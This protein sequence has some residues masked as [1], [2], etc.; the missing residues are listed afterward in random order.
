M[1]VERVLFGN[2][3]DGR[4]VYK[5]II[6]NSNECA[7]HILTLGATL[8]SFEIKDKNGTVKDVLLGLDTFDC[9]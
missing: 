7:A 3:P 6:R 4:E 9:V 2:M 1:S 8:C 5:Y